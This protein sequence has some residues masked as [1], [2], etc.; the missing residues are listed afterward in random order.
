VPAL[1]YVAYRSIFFGRHEN[2]SAAS[3]LGVERTPALVPAFARLFAKVQA[4]WASGL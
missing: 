4:R 3:R 1:A 2:V